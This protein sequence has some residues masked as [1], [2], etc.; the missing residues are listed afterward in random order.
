[1]LSGEPLARW[2]AGASAQPTAREAEVA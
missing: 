1:V 2:L